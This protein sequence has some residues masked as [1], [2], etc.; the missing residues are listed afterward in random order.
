MLLASFDVS[1]WS[2]PIISLPQTLTVEQNLPSLTTLPVSAQPHGLCNENQGE[3]SPLG[4]NPQP[5]LIP[6][7]L[8][9][10]NVEKRSQP[11]CPDCHWLPVAWIRWR[12]FKFYANSWLI[13][14]LCLLVRS[15]LASSY[16]SKSSYMF[17]VLRRK[18]T[19]FFPPFSLLFNIS[20]CISCRDALTS[21][22]RTSLA[23]GVTLAQQ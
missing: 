21:V 15:C 12:C 13:C 10:L 2:P 1:T 20:P 3:V 11:I 14:Y 8:W 17:Y 5:S 19:P 9:D 22:K 4:F 18:S 16:I 7:A 6:F 23:W